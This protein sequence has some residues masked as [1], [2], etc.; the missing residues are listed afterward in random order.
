VNVIQMIKNLLLED[1]ETVLPKLPLHPEGLLGI[2]TDCSEQNILSQ[3]LDDTDSISVS[4]LN[5]EIRDNV[6]KENHFQSSLPSNSVTKESFLQG[7]INQNMSHKSETVDADLLTQSTDVDMMIESKPVFIDNEKPLQIAAI[8]HSALSM[9]GAETMSLGDVKKSDDNLSKEEDDDDDD[10]SSTN[11]SEHSAST[12]SSSSLGSSSL[13]S[14]S[15]SSGSESGQSSDSS[16][17]EM[18]VISN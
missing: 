17:E 18:S 6:I 8:D 12:S 2:K 13:S 10:D 4:S 7:S 16:D 5:D 3:S 11:S 15:S 14:S 9:M 1:D